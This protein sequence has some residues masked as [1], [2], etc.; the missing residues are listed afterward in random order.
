[1]RGIDEVV[2]AVVAV[3]AGDADA[4]DVDVMFLLLLPSERGV[5]RMI[6]GCPVGWLLG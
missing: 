3:A 5:A 6:V 4:V 2:A 1:M